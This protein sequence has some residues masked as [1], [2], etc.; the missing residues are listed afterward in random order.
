MVTKISKNQVN[1]PTVSRQ[2]EVNQ[3][4]SVIPIEKDILGF[5]VSMS[6]TIAMDIRQSIG[7]ILH[8]YLPLTFSKS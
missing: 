3:F 7:Q 4:Y 6:E 2:T 5:E 1:Y 8:N